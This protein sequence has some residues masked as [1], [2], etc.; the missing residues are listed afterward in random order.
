MFA[1]IKETD[2][3]L[4]DVAADLEHAFTEEKFGVLWQ[5]DIHD[6]LEEKGVPVDEEYRVLEVCNPQEAKSLLEQDPKTVLFLPCKVVLYTENGSTKVGL[7]K[8]THLFAPLDNEGI[9][10]QAEDLEERLKKCV[11]QAV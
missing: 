11:Q 1:E 7:A 5:L 8:P 2:R 10:Q 9:Q 4:E 6:K 3:P